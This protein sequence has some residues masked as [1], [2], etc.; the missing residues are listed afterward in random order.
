MHRTIYS[1]DQIKILQT[2]PNV[3]KCSAKSITYSKEFKIKAVKDYYEQGQSSNG[4][5]RAAGFDIA[6]IGLGNP[7]SRLRDWRRIYKALGE[8]GLAKENRG[9][10]KKKKPRC[11]YRDIIYL[12][13]KVAHLEAE[14]NILRERSGG[15]KI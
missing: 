9:R 2:N 10:S 6:L 8:E 11:S 3:E 13:N 1:E 7:K 12:Q 4:I 14:N 15:V 5:F